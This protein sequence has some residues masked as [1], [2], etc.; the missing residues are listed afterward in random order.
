M[1]D[2]NDLRYFLA[3]HRAGNLARAASELAIKAY[4]VCV[5]L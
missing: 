5:V 3:V 2:W 1:V 4:R